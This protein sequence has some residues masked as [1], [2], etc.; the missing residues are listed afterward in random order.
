MLTGRYQRI[1]TR[2]TRV[3]I[4]QFDPVSPSP[5][6][7]D[8][9]LRGVCRYAPDGEE[10]AFVGVDTGAGPIS[11]RLGQWEKHS[12]GSRDIWF[13]PVAKL[14]PSEQ[15]RRIPHSI[16]L[17]IG[18]LRFRNRIPKST[19][20]QM[21]RMDTAL[22]SLV[23]FRRPLVYCVHTQR[24]G[25]TG[26]N[27]DSVWKFAGNLHERLEKRVVKSAEKV[28]VFNEE[29]SK[30]LSRWNPNTT[31][32]P[33]WFDP[34]LIVTSDEARDQ[35][36]VIWVGRVESPKD[37]MLALEAFLEV[38]D[39]EPAKSWKLK[40]IGNGTLQADISAR[41]AELRSDV[42]ARIEILGRVKPADVAQLMAN[43][44]IFLM[45]S[46]PGYEGYPRVLVEAMASGLPAVVTTGSDTG[47]LVVDSL[48]GYTSATRL[49]ID[50]AK[51]ILE[52]ENIDRSG[53]RAKVS[54][55]DAR[56]VV[57]RMLSDNRPS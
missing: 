48:T 1:V 47:A 40:M 2:I 31:F 18:T 49:P 8:T 7:I 46:H 42:R 15:K 57:A 43:S 30:T 9:C 52:A 10:L 53:V 21:H 54:T 35:N 11:R 51:L 33:T 27:S 24:G 39:L 28:I 55:L 32:L 5:G 36:C 17:M 37:P 56:T 3:V 34:Q 16:R 6:G 45:T 4:H 29:Y 44:G 23:L 13:L 22:A 38:A 20:V 41:V 25:L 26:A 14:D 12:I 50:M 19:Y